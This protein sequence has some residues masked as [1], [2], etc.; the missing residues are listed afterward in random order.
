MTHPAVAN[1]VGKNKLQLEKIKNISPLSV[2][3]FSNEFFY[4]KILQNKMDPEFIIHL[5]DKQ[6]K[7]LLKPEMIQLISN[8]DPTPLVINLIT[9]PFYFRLFKNKRMTLGEIKDKSSEELSPLFNHQI[10]KLIAKNILTVD[11]ALALTAQQIK[12]ITCDR[13]NQLLIKYNIS[14]AQVFSITSNTRDLIENDTTVFET[15]SKVDQAGPLNLIAWAAH[16]NKR[17]S[18]FAQLNTGDQSNTLQKIKDD[19]EHI[20]QAHHFDK[21][22]FLNKT[23]ELFISNIKKTLINQP[24]SQAII[25]RRNILHQIE[26]F[27][28]TR[29]SRPEDALNHIAQLINQDSLRAPPNFFIPVANIKKLAIPEYSAAIQ[30]LKNRASLTLENC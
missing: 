21:V 15:L 1:L 11:S 18:A 27:E 2:L 8:Q 28:Q 10:K 5:S 20:I 17:L 7:N 29:N 4:I 24:S 19:L 30:A 6:K 12:I 9:I 16:I 3:V 23:N 25:L 13:M 26:L 22:Q 14:L